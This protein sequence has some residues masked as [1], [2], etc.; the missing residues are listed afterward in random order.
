MIVCVLRTLFIMYIK[1]MLPLF[2]EIK[3]FKGMCVTMVTENHLSK[4]NN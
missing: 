1:L 4:E 3:H 2:V